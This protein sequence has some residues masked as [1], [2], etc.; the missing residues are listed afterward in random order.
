MLYRTARY[1]IVFAFALALSSCGEDEELL[2]IQRLESD[3][4][5]TNAIIDSLN[6]QV[7]T[8]NMLIDDL[9]AQV[10]SLDRVDSRLL[11]N[12]QALNK[13]V[14]QWK[15]LYT[16]QQRQNKKLQT[17]IE[18]MKV[19]KQ[20]DKQAIAKLRTES[21]SLNSGL[22]DAYTRIRRQSDH[23]KRMELDMAQ[24]QDEL[25]QAREETSS[26]RLLV[27]TEAFLKENGYLKTG[28]KLGLFGKSYKLTKKL[29]ATA[30]NVQMV[31]I[32]VPLIIQ[33][34]LKEIVDHYGK[35]EKDG[36]Y[37]VEKVDDQVTVT[38]LNEL[39]EGVDLVAV[40]KE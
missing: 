2:E 21:D 25:D 19:E 10:D 12:I 34:D 11:K 28:R 9:R 31:R 16:E 15:N 23:I 40:V 18:R 8:S 27:A 32:G 5:S 22:V 24:L 36:D 26:I 4:N 3:L 30:S 37:V 6:Y 7:E 14:T 39:L 35:I 38:F 29:D 13:E 33:G 20:A 1:A 17:E